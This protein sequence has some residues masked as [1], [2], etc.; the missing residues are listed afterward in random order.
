MA[1]SMLRRSAWEQISFSEEISYS[2]DVD[3]TYRMRKAGFE[4][5]YAPESKV[6]HSHNYTWEEYFR[7]QRGEGKADA[8]IFEWDLVSRSW[9]RYSGLPY[10][11]QVLRDIVYCF[12]TGR[13]AYAFRVPHIR[14][15][16]LLGRRK[17]F[18]EGMKAR[19]S[20]N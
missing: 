14:T 13:P 19:E 17:G 18:L 11:R 9:L 1:S 20:S 3:I 16:Q 10:A 8:E 12:R 2:E 7:R 15:A 6:Y 4:I 5:K